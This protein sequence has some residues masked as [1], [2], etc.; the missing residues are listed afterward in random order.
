MIS[1]T[2]QNPQSSHPPSTLIS[3]HPPLD[4]RV[5][6]PPAIKKTGK[7]PAARSLDPN[8]NIQPLIDLL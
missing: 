3:R 2:E 6:P 5:N 7:M 8:L 1:L 4:I